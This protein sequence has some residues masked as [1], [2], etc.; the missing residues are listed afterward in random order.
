[1]GTLLSHESGSHSLQRAT[2]SLEARVQNRSGKPLAVKKL[3]RNEAHK[4]RARHVKRCVLFRRCRVIG[5]AD[6]GEG[7]LLWPGFARFGVVGD[8]FAGN[9]GLAC[10]RFLRGSVEVFCLC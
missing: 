9:G 2:L 7:C 10:I 4:R 1:V 6:A 8:S 3:G 5:R